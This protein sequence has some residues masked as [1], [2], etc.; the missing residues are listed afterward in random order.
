MK[1]QQFEQLMSS[2][3]TGEP[4]VERCRKVLD[5]IGH[6]VALRALLVGLCA[7][8]IMLLVRPPF[9]LAFEYDK[10]RPWKASSRVSWLAV[11]LVGLL[12]AGAAGAL[13]I[14]C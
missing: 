7:V 10:T 2:F 11:L 13:P 12:A 9:V 14:L 1:T 8:A 5:S 4:T 3:P 6:N